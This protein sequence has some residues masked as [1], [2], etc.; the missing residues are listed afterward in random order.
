MSRTGVIGGS[1]LYEIKGLTV[2]G[3]KNITTPY[4]K[5]SDD[6]LIGSMG[7]REIVF[8]PRHGKKHGIPPH[9]I[10]YR[11]NIWGFRKLG[12][13]N[14]ISISAV[15]GIRKGMNPGDIVVLDQVLDM[16][17][18][19]KSTFYNGKGGVVHI[20]FTEPYCPDLRSMLLKAGRSAR[21]ALKKEG[22]YVAV[23]GPRLET[24]SEIKSFAILGGDVVGMT[25][26]PEASLAREVEICYAGISVVANFAAGISRRKLSV[27]EVMEAMHGATEKI[28]KLLAKTFSL[29][30]ETRECS[31]LDALKEAKI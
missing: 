1:G 10:N 4:G 27:A 16:T 5:P 9:M 30:P 7:D 13:N 31:C 23:D 14:I 18:N 15:G 2:K 21:V 24:A 6:Y 22:T 11:A 17:R 25:G 3:K 12:V 8:L 20:D 19:R 29:I 28:K 26:M